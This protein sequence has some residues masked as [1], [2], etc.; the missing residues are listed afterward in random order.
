MY[1]FPLMPKG[2]KKLNKVKE[3]CSKGDIFVQRKIIQ[4]GIFVDKGSSFK[5][6]ALELSSMTKGEI[7]AINCH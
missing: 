1:P 6:G 2:E 7:V 5:G 4:R 3:A